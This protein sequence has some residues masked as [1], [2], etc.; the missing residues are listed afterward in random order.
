MKT[1]KKLFALA[2]ALIMVLSLSVS[3]FAA[4]VTGS[5]TVEDGGKDAAGKEINPAPSYNFYKV[6][7]LSY[8]D[9]Y[10][11][12]SYTVSDAWEKF[13]VAGAPG[14]ADI[15]VNEAGY[16]TGLAEGV[17]VADFAKKALAYAKDNGI[18]ADGVLN[19]A[20]SYKAENLPL[21]YYLVDS[22]VGSLCILDTS[23]VNA[24]IKEKNTIP[25]DDKTV[26]ENSTN[27]YGKQNDAKVGDKVEYKC[28]ITVSTGATNYVMHDKMQS[29]IT[30]NNDVKVFIDET[31][32]AA[33][34]Y[35]VS[36]QKMKPTDTFDV[37]FAQSYIDTLAAGTIITVK[38]SGTINETA[39]V[40]T[41]NTNESTVTF[42]DNNE[43]ETLPTK[44]ETFTWDVDVLKYTAVENEKTPLAGAKFTVSVDAEGAEAIKLVNLG[45]NQYRVAT[46]AEVEAD[47][48]IVTE[49]VTDATGKFNV[50]GLDSGKY[51]L[52][53]TAAPDGFN[54]LEE[55]VKFEIVPVK[56]ADGK[57]VV[58]DGKA[59][60]DLYVNGDKET[61][62]KLIE[63]EN[64]SG[65]KLPET[66][67]IGTTIFYVL[68][69]V[70]V[71]GAVV[72]LLTRKKVED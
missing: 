6:L 35:V 60:K 3:A 55:P 67:G 63:V 39:E 54:K 22:N 1:C 21:G 44:T 64:N 72:V 24:V 38:Y 37:E 69:A 66:G 26:K 71:A 50:A 13:F 65:F 56:D 33:T 46:A 11:A 52:T 12:Y 14:A 17:N 41:P 10:G 20:N 5:I 59:D 57:I 61:A 48:N 36:G 49:I 18:A 70:L 23:D 16:V 27:T 8:D 45:D 51:L 62:V 25:E 58:T 28:D 9:T 53:E 19:S 68:G 15:V 31:E 29:T 42:G 4:D 47:K 2:I 40:K 32:V 43:F 30:F 34:N 7:D